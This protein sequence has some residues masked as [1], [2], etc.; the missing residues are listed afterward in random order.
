MF[1]SKNQILKSI[2]FKQIGVSNLKQEA[3]SLLEQLHECEIKKEQLIE[4]TKNSLTPAE[5]RE[6][7]LK[8]VKENNQEISVIEKQ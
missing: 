4:E 8:Q 6:V 2:T 5:E 3:L 1:I 7:L